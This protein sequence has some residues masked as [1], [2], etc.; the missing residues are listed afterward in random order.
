MMIKNQQER[1]DELLLNAIL[2]RLD[3]AN[4]RCS[5]CNNQLFG[6]DICKFCKAEEEGVG[7]ENKFSQQQQLCDLPT[8][9]REDYGQD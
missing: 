8:L 4:Q 2:A 5:Y 6:K 7:Y 1:I 9:R 3:K